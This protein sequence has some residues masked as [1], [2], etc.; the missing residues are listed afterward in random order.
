LWGAFNINVFEWT[1]MQEIIANILDIKIGTYNHNAVSF[2]YYENMENRVNKILSTKQY[3]IYDY[4]E[5]STDFKYKDLKSLYNA[6]DDAMYLLNLPYDSH[7]YVENRNNIDLPS[8]FI[9]LPMTQLLINKKS[10]SLAF[11]LLNSHFVGE[12][13]QFSLD[14]AYYIAAFEYLFRQMKKLDFDNKDKILES[15]ETVLPNNL[16]EDCIKFITDKD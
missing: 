12:S 10:F 4:L 8:Y 15:F 13:S 1:V 16:P 3:N 7:T 5:N 14:D 2:H 9:D 6:I 11:N